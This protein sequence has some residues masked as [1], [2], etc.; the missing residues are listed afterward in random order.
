VANKTV[1]ILAGAI[2]ISDIPR[3]KGDLIGVDYGALFAL[4]HQLPLV[5]AIAD[6]DSVSSLDF[7]HIE[8]QNKD[9]IRAL[10]NKEQSD[11]ELA[12]VEAIKRG[13]Q[14]IFVFGVIGT[15][16]DHF[17]AVLHL[18]SVYQ[19][20]KITIENS[21]N[22]ISLLKPGIHKLQIVHQYFSLFAQK[23]AII[24][25]Q[26]SKY[27]VQARLLDVT[28]RYGLSNETLTGE[29]IVTVSS[30]AVFLFEASDG[31]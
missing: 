24:S 19:D 17:Y 12:I 5:L 13:Y 21:T 25:I 30:G 26:G 7:A 23:A 10:S 29:V 20:T 16:L 6:F 11:T 27:D 18:L 9:I 8:A 3:L 31:V 28:D 1:S 14:H 4:N 2:S 15:R 22:K